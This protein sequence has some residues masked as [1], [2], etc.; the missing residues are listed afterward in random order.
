MDNKNEPKTFKLFPA[1]R[2][3]RQFF[4][5]L[6]GAGSI[7]AAGWPRLGG[8]QS[9]QSEAWEDGDP[10][11]RV[12]VA[13]VTPTYKLAPLL[14]SFIKLSEALTGVS[15]IDMNLASEYLERYATHPQLTAKLPKLV[16]AFRE[17]YRENTPPSEADLKQRIMQ[18]GELR[19]AAEQLIYLWYVSAFFLPPTADAPKSVWLYDSAEQYE[20]GLLWSVIRAHAPM[21]H[22]GPYGY[23]A[24]APSL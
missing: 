10:T 3:R 17:I 9:F 6:L 2:A 13:S 22:G 16:Q 21:T 19:P 8:A 11:C 24:D 4:R 5:N 18:D 14:P 12:A 15:P 23:W 7:A 1:K 20:R